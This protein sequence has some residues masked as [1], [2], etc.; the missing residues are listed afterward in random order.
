MSAPASSGI[1]SYG[2][3]TYPNSLVH[4]T[5]SASPTITSI[6]ITLDIFPSE[7]DTSELDPIRVTF[8]SQ[9]DADPTS[10]HS[11]GYRSVPTAEAQPVA[12]S[13][14]SHTAG[15]AGIAL[16]FVAVLGVMVW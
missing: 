13:G 16:G 1:S 6:P 10:L 11:Y 9:V 5:T 7:T 8:T 4:D 14:S 2:G 15:A 12:N 3:Y